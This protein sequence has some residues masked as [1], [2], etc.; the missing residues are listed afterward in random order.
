MH[1]PEG[2]HEALRLRA[3]PRTLPAQDHHSQRRCRHLLQ[4]A[5]AWL[6]HH[7]FRKPLRGWRIISWLSI[8][9]VIYFRKPLRGWRIIS[10]L[11]IFIVIYFRKPLRGWRIISWL[12]ICFI[13]IYFRKPL[14]GWRIISWL[15]IFIVIY[16]RKP[17]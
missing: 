11:S 1:T 10:W 4:E 7:Y 8:F 12:S 9:I 6:A 2:I 16:F 15:S 14:R 3:L 13:V 17:S 5:P